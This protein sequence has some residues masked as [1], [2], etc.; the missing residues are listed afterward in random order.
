MLT[1][2]RY[3]Y[4]LVIMFLHR[5]CKSC[6]IVPKRGTPRDSFYGIYTTRNRDCFGGV[7]DTHT[8]GTSQDCF[9]GVP[10]TYLGVTPR[11][12]FGALKDKHTGA[13]SYQVAFS[14]RRRG[15]AEDFG[16]ELRGAQPPPKSDWVQA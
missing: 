5:D 7:Q 10:H 8:G 9:G 13:Y 1:K 15:D 12:Y 4:Q 2:T 6:P 11:E 3:F 16:K 14:W